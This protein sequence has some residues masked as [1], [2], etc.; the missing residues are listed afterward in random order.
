MTVDAFSQLQ[1]EAKRTQ[2]VF[3]GFRTAR[4]SRGVATRSSLIRSKRLLL[5][6]T[7]IRVLPTRAAT[8]YVICGLR[9]TRVNPSF[10]S[11]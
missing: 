6:S 5:T 3:Y 10:T 7:R 1:F 4:V 2:F 11:S 9:S 8:S